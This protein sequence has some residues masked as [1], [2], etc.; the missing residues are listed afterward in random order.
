[1]KKGYSL[2]LSECDGIAVDGPNDSVI[3]TKSAYCTN[4]TGMVLTSGQQY[5]ST[6]T[7]GTSSYNYYLEVDN[8]TKTTKKIIDKILDNTIQLP[9][10]ID[11]TKV[12]DYEIQSINSEKKRTILVCTRDMD[13]D[14]LDKI[15]QKSHVL[16]EFNEIVKIDHK[17]EAI[18]P[19]IN[20]WKGNTFETYVVNPS[21]YVI[22]TVAPIQWTNY[23]T[24]GINHTF[25]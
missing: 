19:T 1:M 25:T 16:I 22:T 5:T 17:M 18:N 23:N 9:S 11:E 3:Q 20:L 12:E 7:I 4:T 2:N 6:T 13:L 21:P 24:G 10:L 15:H 8:E 14:S